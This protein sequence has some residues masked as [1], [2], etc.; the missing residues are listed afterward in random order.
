LLGL[1]AAAVIIALMPVAA[2]LFAIPVLGEWPS[3]PSTAA[4]CFIA[5]GGGLAATS[6]NQA[7]N[8]GEIND[9]LLFPSNA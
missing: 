2:T 5:L 8:R 6:S 4:I 7:N 3:W 1:Q 9:P